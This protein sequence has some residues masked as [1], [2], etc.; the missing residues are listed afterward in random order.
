[1]GLRSDLEKRP[2]LDERRQVE[3]VSEGWAL[4]AYLSGAVAVLAPPT[5]VF[6]APIGVVCA[7]F[8]YVFKKRRA[9][10]DAIIDDPPRTDFQTATRAQRDWFDPR[11]LE[12]LLSQA[13]I[14]LCER[15][16]EGDGLLRAAVRADERA[17]GA[18]LASRLDYAQSQG[19][20]S[21]EFL[22]FFASVQRETA[23]ETARVLGEIASDPSWAAARSAQLPQR[24][25]PAR[26][27]DEVL[28]PRVLQALAEARLSPRALRDVR[29]PSSAP[30]R[31]FRT[32]I[33]DLTVYRDELPRRA[34]RLRSESRRPPLERLAKD[35]PA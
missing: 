18:Y 1:M 16:A 15:M 14:R 33:S 31:P 10:C 27:L 32:L 21:D 7:S 29:L 5:T 30:G 23:D 11:R 19:L 24:R 6:A 13:Q 28:A 2:F 25:L 26:T 20:A 8:A 22:E 17:Q 35:W 12:G 3:H 4:M 9:N 34:Q